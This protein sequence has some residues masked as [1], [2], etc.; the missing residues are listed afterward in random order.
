M[1]G[2]VLGTEDKSWFVRERVSVSMSVHACM[3]RGRS[4][5]L[6]MNSFSVLSAVLNAADTTNCGYGKYVPAS[7]SSCSGE[8]DRY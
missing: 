3:Q 6:A 4:R 2:T 5:H 8:K 1:P 7:G